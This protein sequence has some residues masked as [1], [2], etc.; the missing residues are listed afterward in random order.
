MISLSLAI[1]NS[2]S[3]S[4]PISRQ[5]RYRVFSLSTFTNRHPKPSRAFTL[6]ELLV[7]ITIIGILISLLLPA[8]QAAREAARRAQC[9]NNLKQI[10]LALHLHHEAKGCFPAGHYWSKISSGTDDGA[11]ATWITYLLPYL[12]QTN[13]YAAINWTQ[14]FGQAPG[15]NATVCK[16]PLSVFMCPSN[17][18]VEPILGSAYARGTYAANNGLGPMAET[19]YS[20]LP[21]KRPGGVFYLNS[22]MT[23]SQ[24]RDGLSNTAFVSEIRAVSGNDIRGILHYPEGPLYHY[25]YTPNSSVPDEIRSG[26]C[27]NTT[28]APCDDSQF[29]SWSPRALTM[30][31]RSSHSGGVNLSLGDGSIRFVGDSVAL[32]TW[33]ALGTP[34][35]MEAISGDF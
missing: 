4:T 24:V 32:A 28:G 30:S 26:M 19:Y 6:V 31:A 34:Q 8:V 3:Q 35:G 16:T 27:V 9:A 25:N 7:V 20:D 22:N 17:E 2:F 15:Q 11:E 10:G 12:E 21:M 14:S 18:Q 23:A 33:Q 13:L 5:G 1:Q 29:S